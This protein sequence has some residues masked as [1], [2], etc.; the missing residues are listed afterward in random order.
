MAIKYIVHL[1]S[2]HSQNRFY[3]ISIISNQT[4]SHMENIH[5]EEMEEIE[6]IREDI[7]DT[8]DIHDIHE[9]DIED[10]EDIDE[11]VIF[12][13][14]TDKPLNIRKHY[15]DIMKNSI[16]V[17]LNDIRSERKK[18]EVQDLLDELV[19]RID[20]SLSTISVPEIFVDYDKIQ[21]QNQALE[22]SL[23]Y[24]LE[25]INQKETELEYI[26]SLLKDDKKFLTK[27]KSDR[28]AVESRNKKL[29]QSKLHPLLK[30]EY[31]E[32]VEIDDELIKQHLRSIKDPSSCLWNFKED[33][34]FC[35]IRDS[36]NLHLQ[37][38]GKNTKPLDR[39][40][41]EIY[42]AEINLIEMMRKAGLKDKLDEKLCV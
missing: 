41:D 11:E 24:E 33:D 29:Q 1:T 40:F 21:A 35:E 42:D 9:N 19:S 15:V 31:K 14:T 4:T 10:I 7:E 2:R 27:L 13:T 8:E 38:I 22:K 3:H 16:P 6:D 12:Q 30:K 20:K 28:K 32:L 37:S 18:M 23:N 26:S 25:Y 36:I 39:L 17:V 34:E 5:E